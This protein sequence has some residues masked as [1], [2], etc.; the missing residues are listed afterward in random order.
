[1][2]A[3]EPIYVLDA[4]ALLRLAQAE[5]GSEVVRDLLYAATRGEVGLMMHQ[6]NLGEVVY[7]IGKVRGW[8]IAERKRGEIALL[9]IRIV[10]FDDRLF[11]AAV[12]LKADFPIS[13]ADA[14]A[15]ALAIDSSATLVSTDP[16]FDALGDRLTR[17]SG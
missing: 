15:A 17:V 5:R 3:V 12:R 14:F 1:M 16:E 8:E 6:I 2:Q 9:P 7:R 10:A 4:C 11:W 13:Y